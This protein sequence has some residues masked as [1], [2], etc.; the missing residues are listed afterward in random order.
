MNIQLLLLM[1]TLT[2]ETV[3]W[4]WNW[5][6]QHLTWMTPIPP[7]MLIQNNLLLWVNNSQFNLNLLVQ[8]WNCTHSAA[9]CNLFLFL[10]VPTSMLGQ[11]T[12]E[13]LLSH[14]GCFLQIA[15]PKRLPYWTLN[16]TL[17]VVTKFIA[18]ILLKRGGVM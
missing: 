10:T 17:P 3:V 1:L 9:Y 12:A 14:C 16:I 7:W 11:W 6:N 18:W 5:T 8:P 13:A 2:K 4:L 15:V